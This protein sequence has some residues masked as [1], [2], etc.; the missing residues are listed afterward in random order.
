MFGWEQER[1]IG[2]EGVWEGRDA[3]LGQARVTGRRWPLTRF[4]GRDI[5]ILRQA[6][7]S[8][9]QKNLLVSRASLGQSLPWPVKFGAGAGA[10]WAR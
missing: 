10:G 5:L 4:L 6:G 7:E 3:V 8:G 2:R 1:G 9:E